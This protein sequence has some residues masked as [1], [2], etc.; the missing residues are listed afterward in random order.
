[1]QKN[2]GKAKLLLI[3]T[4]ATLELVLCTWERDNFILMPTLIIY[5][6]WLM[7]TS[8]DI[9]INLVYV[10]LMHRAWIIKQHVNVCRLSI[11]SYTFTLLLPWHC[12]NLPRTY[13]GVLLYLDNSV[14]RLRDFGPWKQTNKQTRGQTPLQSSRSYVNIVIIMVVSWKC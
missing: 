10:W 5:S 3:P 8:T 6:I 2:T 14:R 11:V 12:V 13:R 4:F 1:M 7:T 9:L